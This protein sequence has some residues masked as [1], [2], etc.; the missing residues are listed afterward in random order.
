MKNK[1]ITALISVFV[2]FAL[3][4]Y[5]ISVVSPGS[6]K[7]FYNVPVKLQNEGVLEER[8]LMVTSSMKN[9][10]VD[11]RLSGNRT[12]LDILNNSNISVN[13]DVS[14]IYEAG[15]HE[16]TYTV[17]YP[18]EV[19]NNAIS[20]QKRTP[21]TVTVVVE[22]RSTKTIKVLAEYDTSKLPDDY[23]PDTENVELDY[24]EFQITGPTR[25]IKQVDAAKILVDLD[26]DM[27][28]FNDYCPYVLVDK[29]GNEI[30]I[31]DDDK[32]LLTDNLEKR[33]EIH[34]S[35]RVLRLKEVTLEVTVVDGG[36]ATSENTQILIEPATIQVAGSEQLLE[37]LETLN[38]GTVELGKLLTDTTLEFEIILP[39]GIVNKSDA[40]TDA[41]TAKVD[42]RFPNLRTTSITVTEITP[43]NVPAG[44]SAQII[45]KA[46]TLDLRGPKAL[47]DTI[48]EED[49]KVTVDFSSAQTGTSTMEVTVQ[50]ASKFAEVGAVA[51]PTIT[52]KLQKG[53]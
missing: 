41:T 39:D 43:V 38:I 11:L 4:L 33:G 49:V 30:E 15:E 28:R 42:V 48:T 45:T 16:I 31:S 29:D 32:G 22:E 1:L 2:A 14:R 37:D 23:F 46:L 34:A 24:E 6:E 17:S 3:W 12:D 9:V 53:S 27:E 40:T 20:V 52:A 21:D 44:M 19:P 13:V 7:T 50:F 18:G 51:P 35:L 10:E 36:G 8:G 25:I 47:I 5:V 26:K